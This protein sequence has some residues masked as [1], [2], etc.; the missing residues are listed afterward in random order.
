MTVGK[1]ID[2]VQD[3]AQLI[4]LA[5]LDVAENNDVTAFNI[6]ALVEFRVGTKVC[7]KSKQC[8]KKAANLGATADTYIVSV[9]IWV[10]CVDLKEGTQL[11]EK[12]FRLQ[13]NDNG[14]NLI[15]RSAVTPIVSLGSYTKGSSYFRLPE[16][17]PNLI[18]SQPNRMSSLQF[19]ISFS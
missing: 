15:K 7:E 4:K 10:E 6:R 16:A 13:P 11:F 3:K 9:S 8:A 5:E 12:A 19:S 17:P 1:S 2:L 14:W 18:T